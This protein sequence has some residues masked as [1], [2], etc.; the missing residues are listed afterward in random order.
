[1]E[2]RMSPEEASRKLDRGEPVTFLDARNPQAWAASPLQL[3]S[4]LRAPADQ[5]DE[6]LG[7]IPRDHTVVA[8]CT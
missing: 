4:A 6:H 2:L 7:E 8:Y 1:M 3:P 5:L